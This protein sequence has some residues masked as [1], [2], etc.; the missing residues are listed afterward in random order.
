MSRISS[1]ILKYLQIF[2]SL[3]IVPQ[4]IFVQPSIDVKNTF[5]LAKSNFMVIPVV[6]LKKSLTRNWSF[7]HQSIC[8]LG[9]KNN[10]KK[11][12]FFFRKNTFHLHSFL[13]PTNLIKNEGK[14][15][16]FNFPTFWHKIRL[17][18]S[19][20]IYFESFASHRKWL[21]LNE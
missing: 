9:H 13:V 17:I 20:K 11:K 19:Q 5:F 18:L 1:L 4:T 14:K 12:S 8:Q 2:L 6:S 21:Q 16:T 15:S 3:I 7:S 10:Q